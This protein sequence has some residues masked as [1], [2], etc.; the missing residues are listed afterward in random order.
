LTQL[1]KKEGE[2]IKAHHEAGK[3]N[4]SFEP[5]KTLLRIIEELSTS[6]AIRE[7]AQENYDKMINANLQVLNG[8][9]I[10][11]VKK[12]CKL[13]TSGILGLRH[14]TSDRE[15]FLKNQRNTGRVVGILFL[16]MNPHLQTNLWNSWRLLKKTDLKNKR[17]LAK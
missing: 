15:E 17:E 6:F 9:S 12:R 13:H 7:N 5:S 8:T 3:D 16:K 2:E 1:F 11:E 14:E 10:E 4:S